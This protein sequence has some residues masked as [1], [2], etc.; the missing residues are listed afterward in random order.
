MEDQIAK[1]A[2]MTLAT[3]TGAHGTLTGGATNVL[4]V[5]KE[6]S[7]IQSQETASMNVEDLS[8]SS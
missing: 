4:N 8:L 3:A 7:M 6:P 2:L 1:T 5:L